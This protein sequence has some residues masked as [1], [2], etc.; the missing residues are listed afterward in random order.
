MAPIKHI[1]FPFDYSDR[2]YFAVPF[3]ASAANRIGAKIT[4]INVVPYGGAGMGEL[5]AFIKKR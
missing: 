4:A 2:C 5:A 3:V 1:L